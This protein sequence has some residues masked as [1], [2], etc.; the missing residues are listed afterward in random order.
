MYIL[1]LPFSFFS[2]CFF[3]LFFLF[4][5]LKTNVGRRTKLIRNIY[6][7]LKIFHL[8]SLG[9]TRCRCASAAHRDASYGR[10][11]FYTSTSNE[12]LLE[13]E[14]DECK[15]H[16]MG[17][18]S[19]FCCASSLCIHIIHTFI[20]IYPIRRRCQMTWAAKI[21]GIPFKTM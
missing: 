12:C 2:F 21:P 4:F 11:W 20:P 1:L 5:Y 15:K 19:D 14:L 16:P 8:W 6:I 13:R 17:F 18:N 7:H 3:F 9:L 10:S